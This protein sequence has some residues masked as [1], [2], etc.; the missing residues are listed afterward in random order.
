MTIWVTDDGNT[1]PVLY[2]SPVT[3]GVVSG[4]LKSY[5]NVKYPLTSKIK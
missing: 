2:E 3:V 4:R 5:S 1:M